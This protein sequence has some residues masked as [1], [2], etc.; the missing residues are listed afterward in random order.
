MMEMIMGM[1]EARS[2]RLGHVGGSGRLSREQIV[3]AIGL[4]SGRHRL[5]WQV[6]QAEHAGDP[7]ALAQLLAHLRIELAA[8]TAHCANLP[9]LTLAVYLRRPLPEQLRSLVAQHPRWD[10][11]RRRA[12]TIRVKADRAGERGNEHER[13]RLL[14]AAQVVLTQARDR[15]ERELLET[16][17]CPKCSGTGVMARKGTECPVC[18]GSGRIIPDISI[19]ERQAGAE[20]VRA[21]HKALDGLGSEA[22]LFMRALRK[23]MGAELGELEA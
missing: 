6:T 5:G 2:M 3:G 13:A 23:R 14:S 1:F 22:G 10:R 21:V 18:H 12:A 9:E 4:A 16:G 20:A 17:R 15:C 7:T 8:H 19:I 11:E